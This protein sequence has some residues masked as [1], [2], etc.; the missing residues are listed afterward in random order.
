[1][2]S[3]GKEEVTG[4][5]VLVAIFAERDSFAVRLL[6]E[7]GVTRLDV[8]S[9]ISHGVSKI[10][11]EQAERGEAAPRRPSARRRRGRRRT[12]SRRTPST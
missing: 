10:D 11:D 9:Y 6:E 8:V 2:K 7:Q 3:S 1:M 12:R 4:A 5:N